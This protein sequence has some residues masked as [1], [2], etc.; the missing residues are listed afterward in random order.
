MKMKMKR[1]GKRKRMVM[2]HKVTK[3]LQVLTLNVMLE[4]QTNQGWCKEGLE[5]YNKSSTFFFKMQIGSNKEPHPQFEI[6][7]SNAR[8][9]FYAQVLNKRNTASKCRRRAK[10]K[11]KMMKNREAT[12]LSALTRNV[13]I[14]HV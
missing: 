2:R 14:E 8:D 11:V 9:W 3:V 1:K 12:G 7:K 5:L 13:K 10:K 4:Q 6:L